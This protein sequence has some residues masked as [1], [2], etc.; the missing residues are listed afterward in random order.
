MTAGKKNFFVPVTLMLLILLPLIIVIAGCGFSKPAPKPESQRAAAGVTV[1]GVAVGG[2]S[3]A[4]L[5]AVLHDL[6]G[7]TGMPP[8]NAG[9]SQRTGKITPERRGHT[10][11]VPETLRRILMAPSGAGVPPV[12][13][14]LAPA[15]T[16]DQLKRAKLLSSYATP[17]LDKS[18]GRV[19]NIRLTAGLIN[20]TVIESG[21]EFS[22][23]RTTGE[24]MVE[25]GFQPAA[26]FG[27]NGQKEEEV[28]GGMC[29]VSSTLFNAVLAAGLYVAERHPH[30]QPV[31][32]VPPGQD[33]TTYTDKDF[34]FINSTRRR[35]AIRSMLSAGEDKLMVDLFQ[36]PDV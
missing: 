21:G 20:N 11:D 31:N 7:K 15:I 4:E 23:N 8:V 27:D 22:F 24:P 36:L 28:G 2:M 5:K 14:E 19:N 33:A 18:P 34:R 10:L 1:A 17:I 16:A 29:Q 12:Y 30:S 26:V 25:R 9:F 13:K 6:A 35:V 3:A 32:Y